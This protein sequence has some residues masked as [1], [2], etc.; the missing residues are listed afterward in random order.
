MPRVCSV[1]VHQ[2]VNAIDGALVSGSPLRTI[3]AA[4]S[5]SKTSLVRHR[6]H[7]LPSVMETQALAQAKPL[8][9]PPPEGGAT[10]AALVNAWDKLS[11]ESGTAYAAFLVYRDLGATRTLNGAYHFSLRAQGQPGPNRGQPESKAGASSERTGPPP[12]VS[13]RW[14][15]WAEKFTWKE[16]AEAYD[17]HFAAIRLSEAEKVARSFSSEYAEAREL[18]LA[19]LLKVQLNY[20]RGATLDSENG[21]LF[22]RTIRQICRGPNGEPIQQEERINAGEQIALILRLDQFLLGEA[23]TQEAEGHG[24]CD[25][26]VGERL[27]QIAAG[28]ETGLPEWVKSSIRQV[29]PGL[30]INVIAE[31]ESS[32]LTGKD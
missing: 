19:G 30:T 29:A 32:K 21:S 25:S 3:A 24:G 11:S 2:A 28:A 9:N 1:C 15:A 18:L 7:H 17:R 31:P 10:P 26:W 22:E 4:W 8:P 14:R 6:A 13:G 27:L 5:V 20:L 16:R 23:H 12:R